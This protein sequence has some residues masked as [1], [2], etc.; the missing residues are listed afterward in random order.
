MT[1]T[2]FMVFSELLISPITFDFTNIN[3]ILVT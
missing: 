3:K 1:I 2:I